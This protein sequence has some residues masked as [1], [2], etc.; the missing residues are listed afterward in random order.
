M[1]RINKKVRIDRRKKVCQTEYWSTGDCLLIHCHPVALWDAPALLMN[2]LI[3]TIKVRCLSAAYWNWIFTDM[4]NVHALKPREINDVRTRS[5]HRE[6][7]FHS[8]LVWNNQSPHPFSPSQR[9]QMTWHVSE[10]VRRIPNRAAQ[11]Q[12]TPALESLYVWDYYGR[13]HEAVRQT[14]RHIF[15]PRS[16]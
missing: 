1:E 2:V 6:L 7:D 9:Q 11:I 16:W 4:Y 3:I 15:I 14:G 8:D 10:T 12:H 5:C 13:I